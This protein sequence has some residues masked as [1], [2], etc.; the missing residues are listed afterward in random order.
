MNHKFKLLVSVVV[1]IC[2]AVI[3]PQIQ[4]VLSS[5]SKVDSAPNSQMINPRP[6]PEADPTLRHCPGCYDYDTATQPFEALP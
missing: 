3:A 6:G 5:S 2:T 1:F 4:A